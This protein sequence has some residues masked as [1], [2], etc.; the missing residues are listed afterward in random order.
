MVNIL[1]ISY[2]ILSVVL[3][4]WAIHKA[5][6][7]QKNMYALGMLPFVLFLFVIFFI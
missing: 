3:F 1:I 7:T 5:I 6:K 4:F 2:F